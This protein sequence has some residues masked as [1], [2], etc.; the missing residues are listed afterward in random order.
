[1]V[2][3]P[4]GL[5]SL[6]TCAREREREK[7]REEPP[8]VGISGLRRHELPPY[9]LPPSPFSTSRTYERV[10]LALSFP[11]SRAPSPR[12]V[13]LYTRRP[14]A[15]IYDRAR[16]RESSFTS[17][18]GTPQCRAPTGCVRGTPCGLS[19]A[20]GYK[21]RDGGFKEECANHFPPFFYV[22]AG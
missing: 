22:L 12:R 3:G 7:E 15:Y 1:M 11:P 4:C 17:V 5:Y 9:P 8:A 2:G 19:I 10:S 13:S 18:Q 21:R 16:E 20:K 6:Q 14:R